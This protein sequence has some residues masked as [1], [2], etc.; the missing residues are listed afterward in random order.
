MDQ[1]TRSVEP[2]DNVDELSHTRRRPSGR[3]VFLIAVTMLL[4][5][6]LLFVGGVYLLSEKYLGNVAR[7]PDPFAGIPA[8]ERPAEPSAGSSEN[9]ETWLLAGLDTRSPVPTT[10]G[11]AQ[12][13]RRGRSDALMVV[14][15][16]GDR[17]Q[18]YVISIPRDSWVPIAGHG[19][20]KINAA[21]AYGGPTLAIRTVEQLTG[22]R[23]DHFGVIDWAGLKSLTDALGGVTIAS[24]KDGEQ[25]LNGEEALEFLQER[26]TLPRGD[27]DRVQRQQA[28]LRAVVDKTLTEGT[29]TN[30]IKLTKVLGSVGDTVSVDS[31]VSNNDL[32]GLALSL[33]N[34]RRNDLAF[35]T[36]PVAGLDSVDGQSIVRL[37]EQRGQAFWA[38]V[39]SDSL[40]TYIDQYG[41]D[42]LDELAP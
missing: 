10:G 31:G 41:A 16:T 22:I 32:R 40:P 39:A 7:L 18:A 6:A 2:D 13:T 42:T 37:D 33:R 34:L 1:N 14:R 23:I 24:K 8:E 11:N 36:A 21:Y 4:S 25:H 20:A 9:G 35:V 15:L 29:L 19:H 3:R 17:K 27:F 5:V 28:F 12:S 26:K 30:P 38:A